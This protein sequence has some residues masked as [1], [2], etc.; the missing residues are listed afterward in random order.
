MD[1]HEKEM[2]E[3]IKT[4]SKEERAHLKACIYRVVM[5]Y[6]GTDA[7]GLL[8]FKGHLIGDMAEVITLNC[9]E[10]EASEMLEG[11]RDYFEHLNLR[12][13]PPKEMFN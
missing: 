4:L 8:L 13:A 10:M 11:L 1:E 7:K 5:C 2:E 9:N 6:K 12:D 3:R